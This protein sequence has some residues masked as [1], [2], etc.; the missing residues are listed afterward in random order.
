MKQAIRAMDG[1]ERM[2]SVLD[3]AI[4]GGLK[5]GSVLDGAFGGGLKDG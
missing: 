3:G 2:R 4:G 5:D 1:R